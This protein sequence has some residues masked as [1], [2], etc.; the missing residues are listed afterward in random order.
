VSTNHSESPKQSSYDVVIVRQQC[1]TELN[2]RISQ[3]AADC[4]KNIRTYMGS[5]DRVPELS[6][7][8][9]GFGYC[10]SRSRATIFL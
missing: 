1:S 8:S 5:D 7:R 9:F 4:V 2:V 3:F 6:I 10:Q